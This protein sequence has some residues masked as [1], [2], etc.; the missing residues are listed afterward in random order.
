MLTS[1]S[2]DW[3]KMSEVREENEETALLSL[4]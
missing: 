1:S 2:S 4:R 3:G